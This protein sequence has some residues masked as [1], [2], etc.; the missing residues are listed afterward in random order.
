MI[1]NWQDGQLYINH[2][3]ICVKADSAKGEFKIKDGTTVIADGAFSDDEFNITSIYIP[4]SVKG[5]PEG[6]FCSFDYLKSIAVNQNNKY[7]TS[8]NGVL[9]NKTKTVLITYPQGAENESY[10]IP[11]DVKTIGGDAFSGC[12]HLSNIIIL[13][14]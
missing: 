11:K 5:I 4:E 10:S 3:L 6:T 9:F 8:D 14:K 1:Q 2:A 12:S 7:Y 13:M